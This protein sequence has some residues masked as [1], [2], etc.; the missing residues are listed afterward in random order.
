MKVGD[1]NI[2]FF[3]RLFL[4]TIDDIFPMLENE[5]GKDRIKW[6][7]VPWNNGKLAKTEW[8]DRVALEICNKDRTSI[9]ESV[10]FSYIKLVEKKF[11][12]NKKSD[13]YGIAGC[14]SQIKNNKESDLN[15]NNPK[16]NIRTEYMNKHKLKWYTEGIIIIKNKK[17]GDEKEALKNEKII[18]AMFALFD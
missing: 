3:N 12:P 2:W 4:K 8:A 6:V 17:P 9:E 18:Q 13:V 14:K 15:F 7:S 10:Y 16:G 11:A 1:T 5:F